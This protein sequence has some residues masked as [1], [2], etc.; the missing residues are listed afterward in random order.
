MEIKCKLLIIVIWQYCSLAPFR[1]ILH[2]KRPPGLRK[3]LSS[4]KMLITSKA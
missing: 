4:V 1:F 2:R 3:I